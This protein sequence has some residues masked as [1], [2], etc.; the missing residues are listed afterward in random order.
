MIPTT[1]KVRDQRRT[2][3][4]MAA[5]FNAVCTLTNRSIGSRRHGMRRRERTAT[6]RSPNCRGETSNCSGRV[7]ALPDRLPY[8]N[9]HRAGPWDRLNYF[10]NSMK[11]IRRIDDLERCSAPGQ[12]SKSLG[13]LG[14]CAH[15][16]CCFGRCSIC[17]SG[18]RPELRGTG[19]R[20]FKPLSGS[21]RLLSCVRQR[22]DQ[23]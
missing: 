5:A 2:Q 8:A 21:S 17:A 7:M 12:C 14:A 20:H 6:A 4:R 3:G 19:P 23:K 16:S 15:D 1:D 11:I 9:P 18:A 22:T 13:P 10:R